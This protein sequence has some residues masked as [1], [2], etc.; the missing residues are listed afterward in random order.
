MRTAEKGGWIGPLLPSVFS[1]T[2]M[3]FPALSMNMP[4]QWDEVHTSYHWWLDA[5]RPTVDHWRFTITP[6]GQHIQLPGR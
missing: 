6:E 2:M 1:S 3:I 4:A 5:G